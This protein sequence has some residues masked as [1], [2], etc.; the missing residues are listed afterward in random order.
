MLDI[1]F[2]LAG[3]AIHPGLAALKKT[4]SMERRTA[5]GPCVVPGLLD[6]GLARKAGGAPDHIA[7]QA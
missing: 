7:G 6:T 2:D 1:L 5:P 4:P 3:L